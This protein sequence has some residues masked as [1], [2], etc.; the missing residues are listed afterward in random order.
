MI[1]ILIGD[2][3]QSKAQA[4]VNTVNCVGI[5][6]KGIAAEFKKKYPAMYK[7]YKKR[8]DA[9]QVPL[10]EPYLYQDKSGI[11]I[12]NF[13]TKH[14]WRSLS[15]LKDIIRGLDYFVAHINDWKIKSVAIP[16]LGCGNGG[17]EW[18]VI[19]PIMYQKLSTLHV[20]VEIYAPYGTP[21]SQLTLDFLKQEITTEKLK[22][23]EQQ[24]MNPAW[25]TILEVIDQLAKQPYANPVGRII[26]QK[27]AYILTEQGV[28]TGFNFRQGSY[29]PF[30]SE[31]M[32]ALKVFTNTNLIKEEMLGRMMAIHVG[33]SYPEFKNKYREILNTYN[34]KIEK[35]VDLFS[36]IKNTEQAEEVATILYAT[37]K[38]K[39]GKEK[40]IS[41]QELFDYILNWKNTWS[42]EGKREVIAETIRNLEML[43]WVRLQYSESLISE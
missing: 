43:G 16:P 39:N 17:L 3:L 31:M 2:I 11:S 35:T 10:G 19:G 38:L 26:F 30:S 13:P 20:P 21:Q 15:H 24:K 7:D 18:S 42:K 32:E 28:N 8:C 14:H 41:E 6:G 27:I 4:I 1:R 40:T 29:G 37:R 22:G 9:K 34:K 36:R 23:R 12:I 25:L 5:M 33:S